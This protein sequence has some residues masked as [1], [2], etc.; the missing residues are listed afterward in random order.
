MKIIRKIKKLYWNLRYDNVEIVWPD[1]EVELEITHNKNI[2]HKNNL[3]S[4]VK[5]LD[6][7]EVK[8]VTREIAETK[9]NATP[10]GNTMCY[11]NE[12]DNNHRIITNVK[13]TIVTSGE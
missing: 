13:P 8:D 7:V 12:T 3:A 5:Q 4:W 11:G 1:E 9:Y 10:C 2:Y 6:H